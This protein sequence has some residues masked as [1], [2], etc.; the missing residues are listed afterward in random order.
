MMFIFL[1][2]LLNISLLAQDSIIS[3]DS[4]ITEE[5]PTPVLSEFYFKFYKG[6][7][8]TYRVSS[9]DSIIIEFGKPLTKDR[10]EI[11]ELVCDSVGKLNKY[12]YLTSTLKSYVADESLGKVEK[13]RRTTSP[14]IK[15]KVNLVIDSNGRRIQSFVNDSNVYAM[16][17][18]GAFQPNLFLTFNEVYKVNNESWIVRSIDTLAENGVPYPILNQSTLFRAQLPIDTMGYST[19]SA[20]YIRTAT[21]LV[22]VLTE[23]T[24]IL[25]ETIINM[26]GTIYLS[27]KDMIPVILLATQE[28]KLK[29]STPKKEA[30][31]GY[32]YTSVVYELETFKPSKFRS[33]PEEEPKAKPN[34]KNKRNKKK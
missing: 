13:V 27:K 11:Y 18:G 31:P 29:I 4:L 19:Y 15:R 33:E 30:M 6:D 24:Q 21:G 12:Y 32:H 22:K 5:I 3:Q 9:R 7:T 16:S 2:F 34:K 26:G 14:W 23:E 20:N 1:F 17:P 8:L 25:V 28:Q 10:Y